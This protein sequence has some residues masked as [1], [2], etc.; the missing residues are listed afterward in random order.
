M[1]LGSS[2]SGA[3]RSKKLIAAA[4]IQNETTLSEVFNCKNCNDGQKRQRGCKR[5]F[6]RKIVWTIDECIFCEG[7][8]KNCIYCSGKGKIPVRCCPRSTSFSYGLLPYFYAYRNS[9]GLAWPDGRGRLY[10]PSKLV[11]AFDLWSFYFNKFESQ[12]IKKN[13][14]KN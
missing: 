7:K 9:N 12:R 2:S 6:K 1:V 5:P 10:Q 4:F 8:N 3:K 13:V 14:S 11:I